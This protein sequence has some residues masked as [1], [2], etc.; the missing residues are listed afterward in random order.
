[1]LQRILRAA[2]GAALAVAM[3]GGPVAAAGEVVLGAKNC[4]GQLTAGIAQ[5]SG[6]DAWNG[7]G[8]ASKVSGS[9][10]KEIKEVIRATCNS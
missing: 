2:A 5:G 7:I 4:Q 9:S 1:M 10:N 3:V 6:V 8:G